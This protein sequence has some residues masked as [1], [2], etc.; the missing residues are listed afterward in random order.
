MALTRAMLWA[1]YWLLFL[2]FCVYSI[3]SVAFSL[4]LGRRTFLAR[5]CAIPPVARQHRRLTCRRRRRRP[6]GPHAGV[7]SVTDKV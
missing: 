4:S 2:G 1:P 6:F 3:P 5:D 7:P